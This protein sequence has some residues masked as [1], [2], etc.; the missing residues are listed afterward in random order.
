MAP[1]PLLFFLSNK[2]RLASQLCSAEYRYVSQ[3]V[4]INGCARIPLINIRYRLMV[5]RLMGS[6]VFIVGFRNDLFLLPRHFHTSIGTGTCIKNLAQLWLKLFRRCCSLSNK[7][8]YLKSGLRS[9]PFLAAP[10]P[11]FRRRRKT[12]CV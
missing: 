8:R 1:V 4:Q 7:Y 6:K 3:N 12:G 5:L 2:A 9:C 10:T 11:F